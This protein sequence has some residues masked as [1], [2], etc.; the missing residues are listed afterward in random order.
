MGQ[1]RTTADGSA[2]SAGGA[3]RQLSSLEG[4]SE[5]PLSRGTSRGFLAH[6]L[7]HSGRD[8]RRSDR[9]A[10]CGWSQLRVVRRDRR[11]RR[12]VRTLREGSRRDVH[13]FGWHLGSAHLTRHGHDAGKLNSNR[14]RFWRLQARYHDPW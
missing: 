1:F 5:L 11:G 14:G 9:E 6:P 7:R 4:L 13:A 2:H 8:S 12:H 10:E 3:D